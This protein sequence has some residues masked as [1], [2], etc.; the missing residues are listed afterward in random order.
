M[1]NVWITPQDIIK[2]IYEIGDYTGHF[3]NMS[4][5][6]EWYNKKKDIT[7][8]ATPNWSE[9]GEVPFDVMDSEGE[10]DNIVTI[11]MVSGDIPK[12]LTHYLNVLMMIMNHYS[13][14]PNLNEK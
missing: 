12:Q 2:E 14:F 1:N 5:T 4:G 3:D 7:I 6:L 11:K 13:E 9:K 8:F 10:Y